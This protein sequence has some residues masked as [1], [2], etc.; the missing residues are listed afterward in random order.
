MT[1]IGK[2]IDISF[3]NNNYVSFYC[4][5]ADLISVEMEFGEKLNKKPMTYKNDFYVS[6]FNQLVKMPGLSSQMQIYQPPAECYPV[7]IKMQTGSLG[8]MEVFLKDV[9][10]I[11]LEDKAKQE[12]EDKNQ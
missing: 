2:I 11:A 3:Q 12:T 4:N 5:G 6:M 7:K 10:Q 1:C 8:Y 9:Q